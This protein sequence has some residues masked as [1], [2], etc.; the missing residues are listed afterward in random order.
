MLIVAW[1]IRFDQKFWSQNIRMCMVTKIVSVYLTTQTTVCVV[2]RGKT[3]R[4]HPHYA[5]QK[6]S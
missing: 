1:A 3:I 2:V 4:I 6:R 5:E